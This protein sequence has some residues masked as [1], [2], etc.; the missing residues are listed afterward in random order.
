MSGRG[1]WCGMRYTEEGMRG[2]DGW[3]GMRY[4]EEEG[5]GKGWVVLDGKWRWD[6]WCSEIFLSVCLSVCLSLSQ[7]VCLSVCLFLTSV[8][9]P[10][11][12]GDS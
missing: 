6:L 9:L 11:H 7:S 10:A 4:T 8:Y 1:G 2:S 5:D 3:C 12:T